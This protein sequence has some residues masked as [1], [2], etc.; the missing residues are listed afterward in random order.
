MAGNDDNLRKEELGLKIFEGSQDCIFFGHDGVSKWIRKKGNG[1][2][3]HFLIQEHGEMHKIYTEV[4]YRDD[5]PYLDV[6]EQHTV[7]SHMIVNVSPSSAKYQP[8]SIR[9][10]VM[11]NFLNESVFSAGPKFKRMTRKEFEASES[12]TTVSMAISSIIESRFAV[13]PSLLSSF[14]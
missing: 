10:I 2:D 8:Y 12:C 4:Q 5:S 6:G 7:F 13:M 11:K 1:T 3:G 14:K 9:A